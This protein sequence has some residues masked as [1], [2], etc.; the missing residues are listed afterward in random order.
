M[1]GPPS[2]WHHPW[3]RVAAASLLVA[4]ILVPCLFT[5]RLDAVF[6]VPK[7]A[8]LWAILAVA[9]A[10][11]TV[12]TIVSGSRASFATL[13]AVDIPLVAFVVLNVAASAHSIDGRQSLYGERLQ[14]QGLLTLLLYVGWFY[15]ARSSVA[16]LTGLRRLA[17]AIAAGG[18]LVAA[19]GLVQR[20]GLDPIWDGFLPGG[21]VFSSIGQSNALAAYLVLAIPLTAA[22]LFG[23]RALVRGLALAGVV[24]MVA[25]LLFTF[26]R[27]GYL[28]LIAVG[29]VLA[30]GWRRE[31]GA[32]SRRAAYA[33]AVLVAG[34]AVLGAGQARAAPEELGRVLDAGDESARIHVDMWRVAAHV[35]I[36]NPLLGTGPE[37]F[38]LVFP[39][40]SH[41]VLAD[42]RAAALDAYRVESPHDVYLAVAA[43]SGVPALAAYL[44]LLAGFGV[45]MLR[46]ARTATRE[47]RVLLVAVLAAI[48]GH[49]VTDAFMTAEVTSA[50]LAWAIMGATLGFVATLRR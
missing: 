4:S 49:A 16:D 28:G 11:A 48:V 29:V 45:L 36:D 27:G 7:L 19:Y 26:S 23:R 43:G 38:P 47:V 40:Y 22:G 25:A 1:A 13:A 41:A 5:T 9:L 44:V 46:A 12:R 31:L 21:R 34:A 15:I 17:C 33:A 30:A 18:A 50:W 3:D 42:D 2:A 14:Y 20:W 39:R 6:V 32:G 35:A 37:T 10:A 8:A 24:A